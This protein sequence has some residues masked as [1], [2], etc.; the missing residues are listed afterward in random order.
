MIDEKALPADYSST[1]YGFNNST[2]DIFAD[3]ND[4]NFE[5]IDDW[6]ILCPKNISLYKGNTYQIKTNL[7]N[8]TYSSDNTK[9]VS[10]SESGLIKAVE[11]G[12]AVVKIESE[13]EELASVNILV[14]TT[15]LATTTSITETTTS[16][17]T[18]TTK[19]A[20]TT[21]KPATTTTTKATTTTTKPVTTTQPVITET[22]MLGDVDRNNNVD[23]S[24]ASAVLA[25]YASVQTG[26]KSALTDEIKKTADVDGNGVVDASDAS[27]IL[28]YYA[29]RQTGGGKSFDVYIKL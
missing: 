3:A 17:T 20:T 15:A 5:S 19:A 28:A 16:D 8:L 4:Y 1:I 11:N 10:V 21:T 12:K 14:Y 9:A 24:D 2:T 18:T 13:G 6:K 7:D 29:Y 27:T 25:I 22:V 23:A 26:D